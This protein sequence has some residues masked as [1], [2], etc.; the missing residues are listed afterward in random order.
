MTSSQGAS[1]G[2]SFT[3]YDIDPYGTTALEFYSPTGSAVVG[4]AAAGATSLALGTTISST[5]GFVTSV[6]T[7]PAFDTIGTE[8]LGLR[9]KND[10]TAGTDYGWIEFVTTSATGFPATIVGYAYNNTTGG[11]I[12]VGQITNVPEPGTT[13]ALGL[14]AL[15][16]GAVSVRR[17]R[18]SRQAAV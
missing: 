11:S 5:S 17:L 4:T 12:A 15:A 13:A 9:F 18:L 10:T 16:L 8:F 6:A 3:G 2:S 7:G 14:G 1:S